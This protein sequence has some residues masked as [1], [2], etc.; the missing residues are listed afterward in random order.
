ME[1]Q[2]KECQ[3]PQDAG[4]DKD[5]IFPHR[6]GGSPPWFWTSGL[7][8]QENK[9]LL[10]L[11]AKTVVICYSSCRKLVH[12][13]CSDFSG[14]GGKKN[15]TKLSKRSRVPVDC[16]S[17]SDTALHLS[18]MRNA[19]LFIGM[20]FSLRF[21]AHMLYKFYASIKANLDSLLVFITL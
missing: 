10:F 18:P 9:L 11:A 3:Q 13:C 7:Q 14:L 20:Y 4:R 15:C 17:Y 8:G 12:T 16:G 21:R 19:M 5:W 2:A 6:T 1:P